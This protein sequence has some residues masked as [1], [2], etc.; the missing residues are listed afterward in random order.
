MAELQIITL[1]LYSRCPTV[2][3]MLDKMGMAQKRSCFPDKYQ[4]KRYLYIVLIYYVLP[5]FT[6]L[7]VSWIRSRT[8]GSILCTIYEMASSASLE[9]IFVFMEWVLKKLWV[10]VPNHIFQYATL[11]KVFLN[12]FSKQRT[13]TETT[14]ALNF[15]EYLNLQW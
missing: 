10:G 2:E 7:T 9:P 8:S 14:K 12:R 3:K 11:M 4:C 6:N 1:P 5:G 15:R 13:E